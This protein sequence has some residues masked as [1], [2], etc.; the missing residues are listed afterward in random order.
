MVWATFE[1]FENTP[2]ARYRYIN[3]SDQ[4]ISVD[5]NPAGAWQF[6]QYNC[7][8]P[9]NRE[10]MQARDGSHITVSAAGQS[11]GPSDT[12]RVNAW[13]TPAAV[14]PTGSSD[15]LVNN[16]NIIAINSNVSG[17]LAAVGDVRKN[18]LL[19]GATWNFNF[20]SPRLANSTLETYEQDKTCFTCHNGNLVRGNLSHIWDPLQPL[21]AAP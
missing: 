17:K 2:M 5:P 8:D 21:P 15:D 11:I 9:F 10:L 1:H 16:T 4:T 6:S 18:Y 7:K 19:V 14:A 20:G 13:G 12:C 3:T